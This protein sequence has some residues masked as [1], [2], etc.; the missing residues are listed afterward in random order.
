MVISQC[1]Y[2]KIW[3]LFILK[4]LFFKKMVSLFKKRRID[5]KRDHES[6]YATMCGHTAFKHVF[7]THPYSSLFPMRPINSKKRT[8]K[9]VFE[10]RPYSSLF[11]T[12]PINSKKRVIIRKVQL[13]RRWTCVDQVSVHMHWFLCKQGRINMKKRPII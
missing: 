1:V 2:T 6:D 4:H 11:P 13:Y 12:R 10:T 9:H 7:E 5:M 8:I 3:S